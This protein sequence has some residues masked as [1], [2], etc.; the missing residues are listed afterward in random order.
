MKATVP[1]FDGQLAGSV[2]GGGTNEMSLMEALEQAAMKVAL[3]PSEGQS[4]TSLLSRL[5]DDLF[6]QVGEPWLGIPESRMP[7]EIQEALRSR[8]F[9]VDIAQGTDEMELT[10]EPEGPS[11]TPVSAPAITSGPTGLWLPLTEDDM[12]IARRKRVRRFN[13]YQER[14]TSA[15]SDDSHDSP[16]KK[17]RLNKAPP[18]GLTPSPPPPVRVA[19]WVERAAAKRAWAKL[20]WS[21]KRPVAKRPEAKRPE[22]TRP[23]GTVRATRPE[24]DAEFESI[25]E[26]VGRLTTRSPRVARQKGKSKF[27]SSC[28]QN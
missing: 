23:V 11:S 25:A 8:R 16:R 22:A 3:P 24:D 5:N 21:A 14:P 4:T 1:P 13:E 20:P 18:T 17:R 28:K 15:R 6:E 10:G 7:P 26:S 9:T 19:P 2:M 12:I 27:L